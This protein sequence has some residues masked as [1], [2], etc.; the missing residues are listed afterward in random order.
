MPNRSTRILAAVDLGSNSF[1]MEIGRV[2]NDD[3]V[4]IDYLKETV[5]LGAGLDD[6][7]RLSAEAVARGVACLARF[8]ERLRGL[9]GPQ[10]RAV[11]TALRSLLVVKRRG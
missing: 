10:V 2:V 4:R 5:R 9:P 3:I 8:G 6:E 1:R 7:Q 11:A